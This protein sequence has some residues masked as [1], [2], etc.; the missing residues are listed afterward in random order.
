MLRRRLPTLANV[1]ALVF[2]AAV[3]DSPLACLSIAVGVNVAG[4]AVSGAGI[5]GVSE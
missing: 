3:S 1:F 5:R 4:A 2:A